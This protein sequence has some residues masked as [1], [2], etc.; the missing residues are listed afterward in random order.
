[1]TYLVGV[2]STL[3]LYEVQAQFKR[4]GKHEHYTVQEY[5]IRLRE[6]LAMDFGNPSTFCPFYLAT[7]G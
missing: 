5:R 7:Y 4:E 1:M 6:Q 2:C 3:L